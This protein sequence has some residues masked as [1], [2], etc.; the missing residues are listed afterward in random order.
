M[1]HKYKISVIKVLISAAMSSKT[2][3]RAWSNHIQVHKNP[4]FAFTGKMAVLCWPEKKAL[5]IA[6]NH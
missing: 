5:Q 2:D 6:L 4:G 1:V 3:N